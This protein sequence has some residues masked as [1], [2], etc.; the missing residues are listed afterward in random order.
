MKYDIIGDIHG[1]ADALTAL[2]D[3]MGY[4]KKD[5]IWCRDGHTSIFVGD[6]IDRGPGQLRTLD[7]VRPMVDQGAA[8][9]AMGNHEFN[10]IAWHT[11]DPARPGHYLREHNEKNEKQHQA[12]LDDTAGKPEAMRDALNWFGELP[13][14]IDLPGLRVVHACW[15]PSYI[16]LLAPLLEPGRRL[17]QAL[18][19]AASRRGSPEFKAIEAILKGPEAKLPDGLSFT[20]GDEK[21]YE[22]RTR[23]WDADAVTFRESAIVDDATRPLLPN[24][25]IPAEFRFGYGADKPVFF[26]HYWMRGPQQPLAPQVAC[27]DYSVGKGGPLVA[28]R[29]RG[30]HDLDPAH[31]IC[32]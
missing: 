7:I 21:R 23:W 25:E 9:A 5:G 15:H 29:W 16:A 3:K 19:V 24:I 11:P 27:V 32:T 8:L 18:V 13:L 14:W 31:F 17:S 30:E 26:G 2:L 4:R 10:A 28:Y 1:H 6:F 20:M 12:F 22:A